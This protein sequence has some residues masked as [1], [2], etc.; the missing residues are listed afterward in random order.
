MAEI[1]YPTDEE[2]KAKIIE[3]G[4]KMYASRMVAAND[5]NISCRVAENIIWATPSGV[6]KGFMTEEMLVK[7]DL[8]GHILEGTRKPTSEGKMHLRVYKENPDAMAVVHAHPVYATAFAIAGLPLDEPI[9]AEGVVQ[10]GKVPCTPFALPGSQEVPDSIAP[11]CRDYN[12]VLLG[13]HGALTWGAGLDQAFMRMEAV[14][15][16]AREILYTKYLIGKV[17][18]F[19]GE[20]IDGLIGTRKN[21]GITSGVRPGTPDPVKTGEQKDDDDFQL[22]ADKL[23]G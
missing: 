8:D 21:F 18:R 7:M 15:F 10:F 23:L 4:K 12:A 5:G 6:S 9:L 3:I 13:N 17:N 1:R 22:N 14:E 19:T 16:Y 2:A 11:Y 20:Q